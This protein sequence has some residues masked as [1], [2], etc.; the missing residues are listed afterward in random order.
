LNEL[1]LTLNRLAQRVSLQGY[2]TLSKGDLYKKLQEKYNIDRLLRAE[3]RRIKCSEIDEIGIRKRKK[4]QDADSNQNSSSSSSS[5]SSLTPESTCDVEN[6]KRKRRPTLNKID[7]IMFSPIEKK[8]VFK[9]IR[10][11]GTIVRFNIESLVD[12]L[13][14]SGDFSDPETRIPFSDE[15]LKEIDGIVSMDNFYDDL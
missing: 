3:S 2:E 5:F 13:L 11:N 12:F 14:S 8:H 15:N 1:S 6:R 4:C 10:P 7:P 9:F